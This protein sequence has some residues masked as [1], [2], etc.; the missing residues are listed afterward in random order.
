MTNIENQPLLRLAH[1]TGRPSVL[2]L[3]G[4]AETTL[5]MLP[6]AAWLEAQGYDCHLLD[7][8]STRLPT[9]QLA[10]EYL[11]PAL[12]ALADRKILHIVTHS[13]GGVMLHALLQDRKIANLGRVVMLTPAIAGSPL[14]DLAAQN[15]WLVALLGPACR[16]GM[17]DPQ[18]FT[19]RLPKQAAAETGIIAGCVAYFPLSY[20]LMRWP[21]DGNM[22]VRNTR[23]DGAQH[24][25]L[26]VSHDSVLVDPAARYQTA[27]FLASGRFEPALDAAKFLPAV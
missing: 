27:R 4:L 18:S 2:L 23:L 5:H 21:Q 13:M 15:P 16:E 8:P 19:N 9:R 11:A 20:L 24:I 26:P 25:V 17:T 6:M 12:D 7:Y 22:P 14:L 3:H 10:E 1:R